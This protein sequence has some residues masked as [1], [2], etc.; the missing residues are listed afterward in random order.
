MVN[1][2]LDATVGAQNP[3]PQKSPIILILVLVLGLGMIG[4]GVYTMIK[5]KKGNNNMYLE[6]DA[7]DYDD[8]ESHN[9]DSHDDPVNSEPNSSPIPLVTKEPLE[10][11]TP[12]KTTLDFKISHSIKTNAYKMRDSIRCAHDIDDDLMDKNGYLVMLCDGIQGDE[13]TPSY[14]TKR[15]MDEFYSNKRENESIQDF[16]ENTIDKLD[17][18][19]VKF[20]SSGKSGT[21]LL[22]CVIKGKELYLIGVGGARLYHIRANHA[23][24]LTSEH[25]YKLDLAN[26][27]KVGE[28]TELEAKNDP[29]REELVSY[30]GVGGINYIDMNDVPIMLH[31]DDLLLFCSD[32]LYQSLDDEDIMDIV[33]N[34]DGEFK[35]CAK[36]L[37]T[38][39]MENADNSKDNDISALI[40]KVG[41]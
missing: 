6:D 9:M 4:F 5:N 20:V 27:V 37:T 41:E 23:K 34:S 8:R 21:S 31:D 1:L 36:R 29:M 39:A 28:L 24:L 10:E 12:T 26:K 19:I 2:V 17:A 32:G 16:F 7:Y 13:D 25:R 3:V 11:K 15:I 38:A 14:I 22:A 18:E 35:D 30:I 33:N 40:I